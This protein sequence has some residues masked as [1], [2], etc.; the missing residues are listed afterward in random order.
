MVFRT[1]ESAAPPSF[2][3]LGITDYKVL[4]TLATA[5]SVS[6]IYRKQLYSGFSPAV[7]VVKGKGRLVFYMVKV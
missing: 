4:G 7:L 5:T 3:C 1:G 2:I 6:A